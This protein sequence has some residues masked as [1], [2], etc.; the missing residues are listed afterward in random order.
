MTEFRPLMTE[1]AEYNTEALLAEWQWL[2]PSVDTPLFISVFGDWV[3]GNPD[4]SLWLLSVLEGDY[5]QLARNAQEYNTFNKSAEWLEQNFI[6]GWQ[7]IAAGHGM[8]PSRNECLGWKVH[9]LLGGNFEVANLQIF[10]MVVYQAL[11]GQLHRQHQH[12]QQQ[13]Q[14]PSRKKPWYKL[15]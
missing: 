5:I 13:Q 7:P 6:A 1:A 14:I 11:M 2:V 4:G 15:W 12:Q 9:P 3:F 8:S 10:S